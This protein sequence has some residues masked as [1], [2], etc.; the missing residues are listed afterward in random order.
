MLRFILL[1]CEII[2][3]KQNFA[4]KRLMF[5]RLPQEKKDA[6]TRKLNKK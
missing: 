4:D 1:N 3:L 5:H 2:H 6:T